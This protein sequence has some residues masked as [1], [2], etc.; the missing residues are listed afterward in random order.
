LL[1]FVDDLAAPRA[2]VQ[3][4]DLVRQGGVRPLNL[5][6]GPGQR[7]R[8]VLAG[9]WTGEPVPLQVALHWS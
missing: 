6:R 4:A 7:V 5:R 8:I 9:R 2:R 3:L 1:L